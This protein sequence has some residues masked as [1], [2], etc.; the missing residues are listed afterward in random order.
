MI[1]SVTLR[2]RIMRLVLG[3]SVSNPFYCTFHNLSLAQGL[4]CSWSCRPR[5][6]FHRSLQTPHRTA[7]TTRSQDSRPPQTLRLWSCQTRSSPCAMWGLTLPHDHLSPPQKVRAD[8]VPASTA[9]TVQGMVP[10]VSPQ[11]LATGLQGA[12]LEGWAA[13]SG[14]WTYL[15]MPVVICWPAWSA[16]GP[17]P[18]SCSR[19][20]GASS[21]SVVDR[22]RC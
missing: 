4:Q 11:T 7:S 13:L 17:V 15:M 18:R 1:S 21:R 20:C 19:P 10:G 3:M 6:S 9:T 5:A 8:S 12:V 22:C 14:V 2:E 16:R